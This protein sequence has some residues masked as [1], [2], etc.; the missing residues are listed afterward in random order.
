MTW[1]Q[2]LVL[3]AVQ[4]LTEFL[5]I[6]SSAHLVLVPWLFG[7]EIDT[8]ISFA[9][10]VLIQLGTLVAVIAYFWK[11][12]LSMLTAMIEGVRRRKPLLTAQ[13]RLGWWVLLA[14]IPAAAA[15]LLLK[16]WVEAAFASPTAVCIFL[17]VNAAIMSGA[18]RWSRPQIPTSGMGPI[19]AL[20]IGMA[21][22]LALFPGISR[23]GST[24]SAGLM[25]KVL[26]PEAARFS[27]LMSVPVMLGAGLITGIDLVRAPESSE[28]L[29]PVLIGFAA[30]AVVGY[31]A[32]RWLL[33][34]LARHAL[35]V[36]AVYCCALA[37][38]GLLLVWFRG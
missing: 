24:I 19:D 1:Y 28:H 16:D 37:V 20:A 18:E 13:S 30:A 21:Q 29:G 34:Y 23:S 6:S 35:T 9:F 14:S 8:E 32:I 31:V 36:F 25:R 4:G 12:L 10:D 17:L 7:W 11:D 15:G 27:F 26:R 22:V 5:P 33:G 2:A 38:S 3:G